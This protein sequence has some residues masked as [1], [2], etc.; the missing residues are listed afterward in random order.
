MFYLFQYHV[1][2]ITWIFNAKHQQCYSKADL[3]ENFLNETVG[4]YKTN[5]CKHCLCYNNKYSNFYDAKIVNNNNDAKTYFTDYTFIYQ[6]TQQTDG[7]CVIE[8]KP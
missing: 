4:S 7:G 1:V 6:N 2:C 8:N 3:D 5:N